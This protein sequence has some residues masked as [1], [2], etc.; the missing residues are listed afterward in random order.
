LSSALSRARHDG[1]LGTDEAQLVERLDVDIHLVPGSE[2][3]LKVTT[4]RDLAL[5]ERYLEAEVRG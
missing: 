1:F 2:V 5:A 3:N 4:N